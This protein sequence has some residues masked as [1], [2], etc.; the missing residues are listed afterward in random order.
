MFSRQYFER[1]TSIESCFIGYSTE[2]A[3]LAIRSNVNA[4][5]SQ[6]KSKENTGKLVSEIIFTLFA[7]FVEP[8]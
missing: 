2:F 8:L 5:H 6:S 1:S 3:A 4:A 7:I